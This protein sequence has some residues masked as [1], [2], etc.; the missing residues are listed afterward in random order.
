MAEKAAPRQLQGKGVN[1]R[2]Q[3]PPSAADATGAPG[4]AASDTARSIR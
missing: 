3:L 2:N 4:C 1:L